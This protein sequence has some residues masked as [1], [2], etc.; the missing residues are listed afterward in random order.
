MKKKKRRQTKVVSCQKIVIGYSD[1]FS[2]YHYNGENKYELVDVGIVYKKIIHKI[3][4]IILILINIISSKRKHK[5]YNSETF[6]AFENGE[7]KQCSE[8]GWTS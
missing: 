4:I 5:R 2:L 7:E 3:R 8:K 1:V 6:S